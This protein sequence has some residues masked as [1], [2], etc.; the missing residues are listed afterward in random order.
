M[1]DDALALVA[2]LAHVMVSGS[3]EGTVLAER[4]LKAVAAAYG[5][6]AEVA[7]LPESATV[8]IGDRTRVVTAIPGIP[9]LNQ[10]S[11]MKGWVG[12]VT[13][14]RLSLAQ[15]ERELYA[16]ASMPLPYGWPWRILGVVLF[17]VGFGLSVQATWQQVIFTTLTGLFV[18]VLVVG[19]DFYPRLRWLAPLIASALVAMAALYASE[20]GWISGG[21]IALMLPALFVFIPGDSIT[22]AMLELSS[23][24][25]TAGAARMVQSLAALGVLA[26]GPVIALAALGAQAGSLSDVAAPATLGVL[27]GWLGWVIF[28]AGVMLV[29]G[30]SLRD[31]PWALAMVL[32]TYGVQLLTVRATG[33]LV[34]TWLAAAILT[35]ACLIVGSRRHSPPVY[36][37]FLAA[38]FVLTPG[39]HGLR[40]L[41]TWIGG[42]PIQAISDFGDMF[43]LLAAIALG[44]LTAATLLPAGALTQPGHRLT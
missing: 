16:I 25:M 14:G 2:R 18:G 12:G 34:G 24:R 27:A 42:H 6:Q 41:D 21:P 37:L 17:S 29:F 13:E 43:G 26:F 20:Q 30:M 38:F 31:F 28:T 15:A 9:P 44:I 1:G 4:R 39:S 3:F 32:G 8:T 40:G 19:T 22:M 5:Q 7:V 33:D 23:G 35:A 11:A 36:V 10:V